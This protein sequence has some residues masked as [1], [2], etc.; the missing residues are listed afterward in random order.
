[1]NSGINIPGFRDAKISLNSGIDNI[2]FR[3]YFYNRKD[4]P[5]YKRDITIFYLFIKSYMQ[6]E[7]T[8]SQKQ[9]TE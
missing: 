1:L 4:N 3:V 5:L 6:A 8:K 9:K 2:V 7:P